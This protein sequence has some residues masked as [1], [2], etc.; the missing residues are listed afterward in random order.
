MYWFKRKWEQIKRVWDFLPIIWNGFDFDYRY[1]LQLFTY[2]L[3]RQADYFESKDAHRIDA[4]NTASRIRTA[5]EFI[6]KVYDEEYANEYMDVVE[7]LYGRET[8]EFIPT[9]EKSPLSGEELY[10]L[11]VTN[12]NAINEHHQEK[13]DRVKQEM[14]IASRAKQKRA[15]KL[16]WRYIEHNIKYW[17]D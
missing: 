1:S 9:G 14:R 4:K 10:E 16:L 7:K 5:I 11:K 12:Q 15:E 13:I 2:Q 8:W 17:W 3:K 6:D